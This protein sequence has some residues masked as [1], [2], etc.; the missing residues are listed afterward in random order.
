[1]NSCQN[2]VFLTGKFIPGW[3]DVCCNGFVFNFQDCLPGLDNLTFDECYE[4]SSTVGIGSVTV[5]FLH[6]NH[7]IQS[8]RAANRPKYQ[9]DVM[10]LEEIK[11]LREERGEM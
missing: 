11:K 2:E 9:I 6:L 8:K 10:A 3:L 7:L 5:K 1:L 4:K